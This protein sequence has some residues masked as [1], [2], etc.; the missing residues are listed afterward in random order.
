MAL[1]ADALTTVASFSQYIDESA[2]TGV[3]RKEQL[4][5][6]ASVA[7]EAFCSRQFKYLSASSLGVY[8]ERYDG[9]DQVT[10]RLKQY[11]LIDP[12]TNLTVIIGDPTETTTTTLTRNDDYYE[13]SDTGILINPAGWTSGR[14]SIRVQYHA[15]FATIPLD[16]EHA[17]NQLVTDWYLNATRVPMK[18]ESV[19]GVSASYWETVMPPQVRDILDSNYRD[20]RLA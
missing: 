15:G 13:E 18:S 17:T 14:K 20:W 12:A 9:T 3:A 5:N 2:S 19:E 11:P 7:I 1:N 10:L 4:I 6:A 16:L 8:D